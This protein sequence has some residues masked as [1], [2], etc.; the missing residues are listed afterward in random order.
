[1]FQT[2]IGI[3]YTGFR[4]EGVQVESREDWSEDTEGTVYADL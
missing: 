2:A 1:M 4:C 3:R